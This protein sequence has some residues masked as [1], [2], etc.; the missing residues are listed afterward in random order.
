M[1]SL[2]KR[3][4]TLLE[5]LVVLVIISILSTVAVGVYSNHILR[6]KYARARQEIR[7]LETAITAYEVDTGQYPPSG[8]GTALAPNDINPTDPYE[9]SGYLQVALRSSLSGNMNQPLSGRWQGPYIDWDYNRMGSLDG[10]QATTVG[11]SEPLAAI[12]FLDPFGNPYYYVRSSDYE[13]YNGTE[14]PLSSPFAASETWY[15]PST[16]QIISFGANGTSEG[17]PNLGTQ[18]DD[19]SN[20]RGTDY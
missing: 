3:G 4:V 15:N 6:A 14:L 13:Q 17:H 8:S 5:L 2:F 18:N 7:T 10:T 1:K 11:F 19:V 16:F 20:F 12:S 9:G